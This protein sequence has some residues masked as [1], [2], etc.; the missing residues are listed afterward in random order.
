MKSIVSAVLIAAVVFIGNFG[1]TNASAQGC[2]PAPYTMNGGPQRCW[3]QVNN[4]VVPNGVQPG[5]P[6]ITNIGGQ[7]RRCTVMDRVASGGVGAVIGAFAGYAGAKLFH[8]ADVNGF[9]KGGAAAGAA[10]GATVFCDPDIVNDTPGVGVVATG[11]G[12]A[13]AQPGVVAQPAVNPCAHASGTKQG[14]LNLPSSPKHGQTVCALPGDTNISQWL[15]GSPV[16]V[17]TANTPVGCE[18]KPGTK[19]G[20]LN[21]PGHALHEKTVCALPGDPKIS[22]WLS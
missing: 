1:S 6:F 3:G 9:V 18:S 14:T 21:L 7:N 10:A 4:V 22:K 8:Q 12:Q 17:A 2:V 13:V 11:I 19:Q 5:I 20:I 16:A 15:D